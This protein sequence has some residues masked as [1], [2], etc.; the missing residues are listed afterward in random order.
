MR[1]VAAAKPRLCILVTDAM[2][3]AGTPDGDY[4]LGPM[5]VRVRDG[6]A[7]LAFA[8]GDR[9]DRRLDAHHGCSGPLHHVPV[10]GSH[11]STPCTPPAPRPRGSGVYR[12]VGA[13]EAGR[14]ADLVVL[15]DDLEVVR[16]VRPRAWTTEL[17]L[18]P[19]S[20]RASGPE[21]NCFCSAKKT[22]STGSATMTEPAATQVGVG[23]ELA[24][25]G[26]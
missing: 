15:D 11:C 5:A 21:T 14:G 26:C 8:D 1:P 24:R 10:P 20:S 4:V 2:A 19:S 7:P 25:A 18:G 12:R 6:V 23:E 3:A 22:T 16:V 17:N 9:S 13:L